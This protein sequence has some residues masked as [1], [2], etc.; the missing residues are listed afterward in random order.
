MADKAD[1][2][3][4]VSTYNERETVERV[5][6]EIIGLGLGA[7]LLFSDDI[8]PMA[9]VKCRQSERKMPVP[10][11]VASGAKDGVGS[12]HT[13]IAWATIKTTAL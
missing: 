7:D 8:S 5:C 2:L 1:M 11:G 10:E 12:A 3:V 6:A 4:F 13:G 9:L